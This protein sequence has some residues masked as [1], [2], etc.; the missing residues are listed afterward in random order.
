MEIDAFT[1]TIDNNIIMQ[2]QVPIKVR[3]TTKCE[4]S[5]IHLM[6]RTSA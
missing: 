5:T 4:C 2:P 3:P 1:C 6:N